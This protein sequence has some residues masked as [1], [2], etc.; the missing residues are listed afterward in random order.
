MQIFSGRTQLTAEEVIDLYGASGWGKRSD[1]LP[2]SVAK[3]S[4]NTQILI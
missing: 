2:E 4:E 3:A 1:Y